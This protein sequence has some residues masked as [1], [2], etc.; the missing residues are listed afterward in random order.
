MKA[1]ITHA[2]GSA[3]VLQTRDVPT[4][5]ISD[6]EVLI[7]IHASPVTAGDLRLRAADFPSFSVLPGRLMVGVFGPRRSVQG[8]MFAGRVIEVGGAVTRFSVGDSVFGYTAHGAYAEYL[9][10]PEGGAMAR[11]PAGLGYDEAAAVPYGAGTA[12]HFLRDLGAVGAGDRVLIVG[13]SG[14]VGRFAVQLAK[15]LGAEVTGVCSRS[16]FELVRSLGADHVID[17]ATEDF[18]QRGQRYDVIFDIAGATSFG[19]SRT[20]LTEE[21]RYLTPVLSVG[22]LLQVALTAM[23]GGPR[24]KFAVVLPDQDDMNQLRALL[25]QGVI[26]PVIARRFPLER[27]AEAHAEAETGRVHGS[28]MVTLH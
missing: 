25:E 3:D 7:R 4:P 6:R 11:M 20:S 18:T 28:V 17:Y 23:S 10:M 14:G 16:S 27:I 9:S 19:R 15:H 21:G 26:R 1:A 12:L 24:A 2:Y 5:T 8:T 13:A 22:L